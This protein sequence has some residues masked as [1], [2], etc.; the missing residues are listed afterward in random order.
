MAD[1][2]T[3]Q[4]ILDAAEALLVEHGAASVSLRQITA[5]AAVNLAAVNY[6]FGSKRSLIHAVLARHLDPLHEDRLRVLDACETSVAGQLD[7]EHVLAALFAPALHRARHQAGFLRFVGRVYTDPSPEIA[8]F[9]HR[10][11]EPVTTRFSAAFA[12][13]LPGLPH[14]ELALRLQFVLKAIA[15]I[16]ASADL[17]DLLADIGVARPASITDLELLARLT[18]LMVGALTAPDPTGGRDFA[19]LFSILDAP[20]HDARPPARPHGAHP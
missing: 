14:A 10:R 15:G 2:D 17:P 8:D 13:A 6:H 7:C 3:K 18:T 4:R 1:R 20:T 16:I 11:Y 19:D 5:S 12:A 9:I